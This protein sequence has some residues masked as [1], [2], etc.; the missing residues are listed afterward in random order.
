[1]DKVT[2]DKTVPVYGQIV[3]VVLL[4]ILIVTA[5]LYLT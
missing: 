1:M 5:A 3:G 2:E 4:I